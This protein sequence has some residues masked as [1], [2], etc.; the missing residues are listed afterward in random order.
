MALGSSRAVPPASSPS[1]AAACVAAR[2]LG[3][4]P[5]RASARPPSSRADP[6]S[7]GPA[8]PTPPR[9]PAPRR[10]AL[11]GLMRRYAPLSPDS[12][13]PCPSGATHAMAA[14]APPGQS[15]VA[16]I[17]TDSGDQQPIPTRMCFSQ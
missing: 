14:R 11:A 10:R 3:S 5:P 13:P 7:L 2:P 1:P 12:V 9:S 16:R 8:G 4:A 17:A 15:A 6:R